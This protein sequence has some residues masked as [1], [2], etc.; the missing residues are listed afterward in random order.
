M[1]AI[2]RYSSGDFKPVVLLEAKSSG[3]FYGACVFIRQME[4]VA[5]PAF[6][7]SV[8]EGEISGYTI[9]SRVFQ[10]AETGWILRLQ[11]KTQFQRMGIG[12]SLVERLI[13]EFQGYGINDVFLSVSPN[14]LSALSLYKSLGFIEDFFK[15]EYFG[16]G[17]DRWILKKTI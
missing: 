12:R 6:F 14:N 2:R 13:L 8:T 3:S 10:S 17:E 1:A 4:S 11:V 9:G 5:Q 16:P 7:V 15:E